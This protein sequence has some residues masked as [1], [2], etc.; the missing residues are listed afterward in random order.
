MFTLPLDWGWEEEPRSDGGW[1]WCP[2]ISRN[3]SRAVGKSTS[4]EQIPYLLLIASSFENNN[5]SGTF[6]LNSLNIYV[7]IHKNITMQLLCS[8]EQLE[9]CIK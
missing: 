1:G 2:M 5:T 3:P 8:L 9:Y 7:E 4:S 6:H